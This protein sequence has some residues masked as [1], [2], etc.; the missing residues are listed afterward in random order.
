MNSRT[1]TQ[2]KLVTSKKRN[3]AISISE[4]FWGYIVR[5]G[6][7]AP[8]RAAMGEI[9]AMMSTIFLGIV[10][11]SQWLLPDEINEIF[12]VEYKIAGT[13]LLFVF[14]FQNYTIAR[15]GLLYETQVDEKRQELRQAR[16]NRDGVSMQIASYPFREVSRIYAVRS[17]AD[18][19]PDRLYIEVGAKKKPILIAMGKGDELEHLRERLIQDIRPTTIRPQ[20]PVVAAA[21]VAEKRQVPTAFAAQ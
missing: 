3:S 10:A 17:K 18:F 14:A 7:A 6:G 8:K 16:R 15:R 21:R 13:I 19:V 9:V 20:R 5:K 2:D 4:T 12:A 11:Y 1:N